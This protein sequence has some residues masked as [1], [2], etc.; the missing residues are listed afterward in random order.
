MASVEMK[1]ISGK[2]VGSIELDDTVFATEMNEH[3]LW[4]V[5]KWQRAKRRSGNASTKTRGEIRAT[6]QKPWKQKGT[7][8]ARAGDAKSPIWRGGGT[9][10]GPKPRS[11][12]YSMPR[13]ARQKAL[14]SALSLRLAENQLVVVDEFKANGKT[15]NVAS[16]LAALGCTQ[17]DSKALIVDVVGNELLIRGARNLARSKWLAP[18]GLNVYD[19]LNHPTLVMTKES[20]AKVTETLRS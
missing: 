18:E 17:P 9:T 20:V 3:L 12:A 2:A 10:F 19:V 8:R 11:Y 1:D 16:S 14:R 7:G 5:V 4:E 6:N 15:K 13:K